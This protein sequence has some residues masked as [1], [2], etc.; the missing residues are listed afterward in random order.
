DVQ[1]GFDPAGHELAHERLFVDDLAARGVDETAT[2]AKKSQP[3]GIEQSAR[4]GSQRNVQADD[5]GLGEQLVELA[6]A[7]PAPPAGMLEHAHSESRGAERHRLADPAEAHDSQRRA[8][9][10]ATEEVGIGPTAAPPALANRE[11]A[12]ADA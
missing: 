11:V 6:P 5:V 10:V 1:A 3:R 8:A 4:L 12:D 7:L 2:V 9:D